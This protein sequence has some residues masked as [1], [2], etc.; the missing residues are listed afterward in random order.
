MMQNI[1]MPEWG[2]KILKTAQRLEQMA[3]VVYIRVG[4][5]A[6]GQAMKIHVETERFSGTLELRSRGESLK[7]HSRLGSTTALPPDLLDAHVALNEARLVVDLTMAAHSELREYRVWLDE[8]PC[9]RCSATG[10]EMGG[11]CRVCKGSG[12]RRFP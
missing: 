11:E 5:D 7:A 4:Y 3:G 9:D 10:K 6:G 12:Y 1:L 2:A 8:A